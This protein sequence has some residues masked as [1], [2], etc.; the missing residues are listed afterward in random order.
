MH[1]RFKEVEIHNFLSIGDAK[2]NFENQGY[3]LV[4]GIN[5]VAEDCATSNGVGK[6]SIFDSII[7]NLTGETIRGTKDVINKY[8][9]GGTFVKLTFKI[10]NDLYVIT[11]YKEYENIGTNLKIEI[12]GEDKSGK[13]IR[14][15]EKLL[16]DYLPDLNTSLLGSVIILG[17]GLPQKFTSNTP[18]GRKEVLEKLSKSDYMIQDIKNK[19]SN[20]KDELNSIIR[21]F[22]DNILKN[23]S[24]RVVYQ[25]Q[26]VS[27]NDVLEKLNNHIDFDSEIN[28]KKLKLEEIIKN[29]TSYEELLNVE[30][31][32]STDIKERLSS[33]KAEIERVKLEA[34]NEKSSA[35]TPLSNK[36]NE[37]RFELRTLDDKV[38]AILDRKDICPYCGQKIHDF[39]YI[40][41]SKDQERIAEIKTE[42][43]SLD[44][45]INKI[46]T[47]YK[48]KLSNIEIKYNN[49]INLDNSKLEI[50]NKNIN[51][52]TKSLNA[53][54][55]DEITLNNEITKLEMERDN[56]VL[57]KNKC[58]TNINTTT[59]K[60]NALKAEYERLNIEKTNYTEHLNI[61]SNMITLTNRDFRGILLTNIINYINLKAK[62][63][64]LEVFGTESI[65]FKLDG[66][67][68]YV[69]YNDKQ[70][71]NLSGGE[72]Q[73]IDVIIQF[74]LR[75]MLCK[76]L[77]FTSNILCVDEIFDA[78]D[79]IGCQRLLNLITKKFDDIESTYIITH[80]KDLN[81]PYDKLLTIVKEP[82]NISNILI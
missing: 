60:I 74:C 27:L 44:I 3:V 59:D 65:E 26:L 62:E 57:N 19:L 11:R 2:V 76:F 39:V 77:D 42:L 72:K 51:E 56:L 25:N 46:D 81:I 17:Q 36:Y 5:K 58:E 18:A 80:H 12:N 20:R 29:K 70:Y 47:S 54:K 28:N 1:I 34:L 16:E 45:E 31:Q 33:Y 64:S 10:N 4:Q 71:E 22:E 52:L 40:D 8:T 63:C 53:Y 15:T 73:K 30:I 67:N 49:D 32:S 35:T 13:G 24:Q 43:V 37:L 78:L 21:N 55:I 61:V 48:E 66:N 23:E 69:G 9:S 75:D 79:E 68:I 50:C 82:N 6:S 7:W 41:T 38:K 14:D